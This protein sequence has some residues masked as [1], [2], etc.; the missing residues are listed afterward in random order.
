MCTNSIE[1]IFRSL[2]NAFKGIYG[3]L[4]IPKYGANSRNSHINKSTG[5]PKI[6]FSR[7][8]A[9]NEAVERTLQTGEVHNPYQCRNCGEYHI[10]HGANKAPAAILFLSLLTILIL[11]I[12][13]LWKDKN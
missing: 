7:I 6:P 4:N 11:S 3:L 12:I 13:N 1:L 9:N 8:G 10:G 5:K 2:A